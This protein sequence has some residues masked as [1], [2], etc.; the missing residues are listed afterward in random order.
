MLDVN[1]IEN[2]EGAKDKEEDLVSELKKVTKIKS[3]YQMMFYSIH[4]GRNK[5]PLH[6]MTGHNI[7]DKCKSRELRTSLNRIGVC[8]SYNE[9]Q[10][11]RTSLA[12]YSFIQS[13]KE[14][15]PIPSHFD[16]T[17]FTIAAF[18]N[19]DHADRSSSSGMLSNHDTVTVLFQTKPDKLP[20]KTNQII[21]QY[22]AT[23]N[24]EI[25]TMSR[26]KIV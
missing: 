21:S 8:V 14:N 15:V 20:S 24:V 17:M 5:T 10:R 4:K 1:D 26:V 11:A 23:Y 2:D 25:S 7:Y 16:R 9:I 12:L 13:K 18:D 19:F 22:A 3:L 6:V